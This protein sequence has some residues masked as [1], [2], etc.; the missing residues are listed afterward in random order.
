MWLS[1]LGA[2]TLV[3]VALGLGC[4]AP[5]TASREDANLVATRGAGPIRRWIVAHVDTKAQQHS[6]AGRLVAIW[7]LAL[8]VGCLTALAVLRGTSGSPVGALALAS[9]SAL[10]LVAGILAARARLSGGSPGARDNGSGLV[11]ALTA[12]RVSRD[13]GVGI[14]ITGAEEFGLIGARAFATVHAGELIGAEVINLD[15]LADRGRLYL[16]SHDRR[17]MEL[18]GQLTKA[19]APLGIPLVPRRMPAGILVDSL[20]FARR[21]ALALTLSRLDWSTLRLMHTP[22]D[23]LEGLDLTTATRVGE[24]VGGL[25]SGDG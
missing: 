9:G 7:V 4:A 14:L 2:L 15:T 18:A 19:L 5:G 12:A 16:V 13:P 10:S 21:G 22:Q 24:V 8:A 23:T 6:M 25:A 20:A 1:G 11:A 17:G 3:G